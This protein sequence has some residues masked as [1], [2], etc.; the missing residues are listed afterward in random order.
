MFGSRLKQGGLGERSYIMARR[1]SS[2]LVMS[3]RA[4]SRTFFVFR[5]AAVKLVARH[6][7]II[8][9]RFDDSFSQKYFFKHCRFPDISKTAQN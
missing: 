3:Q 2:T 9:L 5:P 7:N 6:L 1:S 4:D 8:S